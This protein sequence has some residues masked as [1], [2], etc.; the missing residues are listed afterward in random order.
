MEMDLTPEQAKLATRINNL[1]Q[2]NSD[3]A[4]EIQQ[5]G[6][7]VD[8]S[9]ARID[10]FINFLREA[11]HF[12]VQEQLE[13]AEKWELSLREQL[14]HFKQQVKDLA[15]QNAQAEKRAKQG[16]PPVKPPPPPRLWTP[17]SN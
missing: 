3:M 5:Y 11:G 13:E 1:R 7:N 6:A 15:R 14:Q 17:G 8:L 16:L 10:H 4:T 12:T 2:R 9:I